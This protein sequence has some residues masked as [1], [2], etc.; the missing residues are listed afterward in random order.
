MS[1]TVELQPTPVSSKHALPHTRTSLD[2]SYIV[3]ASP[4]PTDN[5]QGNMI[6]PSVSPMPVPKGLSIL[7]ITLIILQPSLVNF[8]S[9]FTNGIITVGLPSIAHSINLQRSLY[10]WP[11]SVY[12]LTSGAMLLIAGSVADIIG[13]RI[14]EISGILLLGIFTL[15]CGLSTS[16]VQLVVF[17]ALQGI[18]FAMHLPASVA[19]VTGAVPQGRARNIGFACLGLSQPLGFS[20]GMVVSGII[21]ERAGWRTGF[22]AS[23]GATLVTVI[24]ALWTLP[25]IKPEAQGSENKPWYKQLYAEVDWAGG[26]IAGGGLAILAYILA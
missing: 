9:S 15:S 10:F 6:E 20:V 12:G 21:V 1:Q 22:Y 2:S 14:V 16:G 23:G 13:A 24:T 4:K 11:I 25:K 7:K 3:F 19:L 5:D 8:L 18:G 17:R 26:V